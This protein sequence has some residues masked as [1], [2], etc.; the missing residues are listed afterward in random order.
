[1]IDKEKREILLKEY[2]ICQQDNQAQLSRYWTIFSIFVSIITAVIG[3]L[4]YGLFNTNIIKTLL[5]GEDF[6]YTIVKFT[7]IFIFLLGIFII[8]TFLEFSLNRVYYIIQNNIQRMLEIEIELDMWKELSIYIFDK[9]N[10]IKKK[11]NIKNKPCDS[12]NKEIWT[13]VW[14]ELSTELSKDYY[15]S[16]YKEKN[17]IEAIP[18]QRNFSYA[19]IMEGKAVYLFWGIRWFWVLM[20]A[21]IFG[22]RLYQLSKPPLTYIFYFILF[23]LIFTTY[24]DIRKKEHKS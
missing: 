24:I 4:V 22:L 21:P 10:R 16:I 2:E 13:R 17:R 20:I 23:I 5:I 15:D 6:P 3:G 8:T 18:Y 14:N 1:M 12:Q 7:I 11:L 19:W 9:W